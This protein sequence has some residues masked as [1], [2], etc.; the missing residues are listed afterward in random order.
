[1][2]ITYRY[3]IYTAENGESERVHP[4]PPPKKKSKRNKKLNKHI[5]RKKIQICRVMTDQL[6]LNIA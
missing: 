1:M 5:S 3:E 4:P 2:K 6:M